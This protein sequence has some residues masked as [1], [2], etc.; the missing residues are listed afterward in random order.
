MNIPVPRVVY[1]DEAILVV[2]KPS[3]LPSVPARTPLDHRGG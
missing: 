3:G 1:A 2:D